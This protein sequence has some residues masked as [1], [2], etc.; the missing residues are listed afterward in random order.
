MKLVP[1]GRFR[2]R[3][4]QWLTKKPYRDHMRAPKAQSTRSIPRPVMPP[5]ENAKLA[6]NYYY[7]R[8]LRRE[9]KPPVSILDKL[10]TSGDKP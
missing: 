7:S 6:G 9:V 10:I 4:I 1:G 5:T 8:D 2:H 3:L